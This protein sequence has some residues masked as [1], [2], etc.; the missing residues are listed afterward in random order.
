MGPNVR[1]DPTALDDPA[2]TDVVVLAV[3]A[4]EHRLLAERALD[5]GQHVVSVGDS[6]ADIGLL[7][8][9]DGEAE[10]KEL[11]VLCGAGLSPGLT[12]VL[13]RHAAGHFDRVDEIHVAQH[14]TGGPACARHHHEAMQGDALDW[15]DGAWRSRRGRTGRELVWFP[16]PVGGQDCYRAALPGARLLAPY[17]D[18]VD[19]VTVRVSATRRDRLTA[20]LPMMRRPHHDGGPGAVHVEVRGRRG[21]ETGVAVYGAMDHPSVAAATVAATAVRWIAAGTVPAGAHGLAVIDDSAGFLGELA[22]RGVKAA[23]FEGSSDA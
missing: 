15:R 20:L 6:M 1:A 13:A 7:L 4:D 18:G 2:G 5:T 10:T 23:I 22:R 16:E 11:S 21:S 3:A 8:E 9:L 14:G 19:R 12:C 17:F